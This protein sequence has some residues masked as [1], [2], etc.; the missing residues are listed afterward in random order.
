MG[1]WDFSGA[2]AG[3]FLPEYIKS[4]LGIAI[5]GMFL[6]IIIPP[7]KRSRPVLGVVLLASAMSCLFRFT[8]L[9]REISSGFV[10]I[11][12]ALVG[13]RTGG[14]TETCR[15]GDGM[16]EEIGKYA[17]YIA[18]MAGVTYFIRMLPLTVFRKKIENRYI[19]SFLYYVPYAVLG[20]MTFPD[21]FSSTAFT[22]SAVVGVAVAILLAYFEKGLLTVALS[23]CAAVFYTERIIMLF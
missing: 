10:I 12:C 1:V 6:A 2:A 13:S 8:P 22:L 3:T 7:S 5:Y 14:C 9:L 17:M 21:V 19:K 11:I 16:I 20:A 18:V 4:A 15:G 23:A